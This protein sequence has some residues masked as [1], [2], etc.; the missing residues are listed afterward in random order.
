MWTRVTRRERL[1]KAPS[2]HTEGVRL[3]RAVAYHVVAVPELMWLHHIPNGGWRNKVVAG[4]LKSE[5]V[6]PG[7]ADYFLPVA[8]QGFHGLY[9]ELK[10]QDGRIS[11]V[12]KQFRDFVLAQGYQYHLAKG[13]EDAYSSIKAY[14]GIS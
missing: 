3:M 1:G 10:A 5:G 2:E 6:K 8:R 4:K 9:I 14:L 11:D 7:V 13:W 12:Q